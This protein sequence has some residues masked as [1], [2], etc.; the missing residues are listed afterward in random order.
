MTTHIFPPP[1]PP[2]PPPPRR[3]G[4]HARAARLQGQLSGA[5]RGSRQFL[6]VLL[7][8]PRC[9]EDGGLG[10]AGLPKGTPQSAQDGD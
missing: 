3:A 9:H 1:P 5:I 8:G 2:P 6:L 10:T 7:G 4:T